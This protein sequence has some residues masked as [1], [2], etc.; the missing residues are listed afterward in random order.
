[1]VLGASKLPAVQASSARCL[2]GRVR[3]CSAD[4]SG[5]AEACLRDADGA[6]GGGEVRERGGQLPGTPG[7]EP[8]SYS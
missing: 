2:G 6:R 5:P 3:A 8:H 7:L 4:A 1:M